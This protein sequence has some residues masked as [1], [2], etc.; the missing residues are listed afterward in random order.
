V[1]TINQKKAGVFETLK[2][3]SRP[4][5]PD[6]ACCI[7]ALKVALCTN[8]SLIS[9]GGEPRTPVG[10]RSRQRW[11]TKGQVARFPSAYIC[12]MTADGVQANFSDDKDNMA[13]INFERLPMKVAIIDHPPMSSS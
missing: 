12:F 5:T 13:I 1:S 10:C 8:Q 3:K 11:K 4:K 6:L 2:L 7:G 9:V